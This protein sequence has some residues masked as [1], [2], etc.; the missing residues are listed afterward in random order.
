MSDLETER[1]AILEKIGQRGDIREQVLGLIQELSTLNYAYCF[2]WMGLP[3]I[4]SPFD[5]V[6][7]QQCIWEA[8]PDVIIE[9][10][11]ARGGSLVLS[12]SM[13]KLLDIP[14][15]VIGI[16]IDI[17]EH[18]RKALAGHP[19]KSYI[20][21]VEGSSVAPEV[22][23]QVKSL[24]GSGKKVMVMLDSDHTYDHVLKELECYAPLVTKSSY[25]IVMDTVI[26]DMPKEMFTNRP[27]GGEN[28]PKRAIRDYLQNCD[29]F[30][31]LH[32]LNHKL[33]FTAAMDGYLKCVRD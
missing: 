13:L 22:V 11:V 7:I 4:Q 15:K 25:L 29:R 24:M 8:R 16:D 20:H 28:N 21:T 5:I 30:E 27:W 1:A 10:G 23:A 17:R 26:E 31:V 9:T 3:I 19:L 32:A 12:A 2:D 14:G 33:L 6:Q 18:T